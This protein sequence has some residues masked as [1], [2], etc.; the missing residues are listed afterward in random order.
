M[1]TNSVGRRCLSLLSVTQ[2]FVW[3]NKFFCI[4]I[5]HLRLQSD[6][7]LTDITM[8]RHF[9]SQCSLVLFFMLEFLSNLVRVIMTRYNRNFVTKLAQINTHLIWRSHICIG[10][11]S[12]SLK[13]KLTLLNCD[14]WKFLKMELNSRQKM[15]V[16][17][18]TRY[19]IT[20][21]IFLLIV[22]VKKCIQINSFLTFNSE[23]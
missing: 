8:L 6:I 15:F 13:K 5:S 21:F 4:L 22:I 17:V 3:P 7:M 12:L 16:K 11:Y 9:F 14:L 18:K 20:G 19:V 1:N 2:F 10:L 23:K